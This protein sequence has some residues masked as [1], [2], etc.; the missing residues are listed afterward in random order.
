LKIAA[1]LTFVLIATVSGV[2]YSS[3]ISDDLYDDY[4]V[5]LN[6]DFYE[7]SAAYNP[8]VIQGLKSVADRY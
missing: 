7:V 3:N 8:Q 6:E 1:A 2:E 4:E 5:A